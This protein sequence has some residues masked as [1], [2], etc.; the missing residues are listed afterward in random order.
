MKRL[1]AILLIL[2]LSALTLLGI[3]LAARNTHRVLGDS[4]YQPFIQEIF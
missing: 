1:I 4:N 2:I 3:E